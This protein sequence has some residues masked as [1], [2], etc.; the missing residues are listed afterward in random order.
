MMRYNLYNGGKDEAMRVNK[1]SK[2]S[3][4][5][6]VM[7]D[8]RRQVIDGMDLSWSTYELEKEHIPMLREYQR[9]SKKTLKLYWK[10]FSL[11]ER[12]LLD[13]LAIEKDLKNA[14]DE[15]TNAKYNLLVSK[16]R[17][18]D[19]MGLTMPSVIGNVKKYYKRVGLFNN[20][21][22]PKDILPV[23]YDKDRDGV[24]ADKD[25]EPA[26]KK[27]KY[28][29]RASGIRKSSDALKVLRGER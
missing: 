14:N 12:S 3:Q 27:T 11:G 24:L 7:N 23:S 26:S 29:V 28:G 4:E 16:Y 1:M 18:F 15:I 10:E 9:Q 5:M 21:K 19:A 20:G 22:T 2:I 25:L 17:I 6:E 8:L 13:L